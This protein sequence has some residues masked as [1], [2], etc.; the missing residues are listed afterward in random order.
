MSCF[1]YFRLL[2]G[3]TVGMYLAQQWQVQKPTIVALKTY[4]SCQNKIFFV[5]KLITKKDLNHVAN[6]QIT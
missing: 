3:K 1:L 2:T 4:E 5:L 6:T